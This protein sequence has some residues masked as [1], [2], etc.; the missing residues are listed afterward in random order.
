MLTLPSVAGSTASAI[1]SIDAS[2][3][4]L[5]HSFPSGLSVL[6][7]IGIASPCKATVVAQTPQDGIGSGDVVVHSSIYCSPFTLSGPRGLC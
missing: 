4:P 3:Q 6:S 2:F 5:I 1:L 7:P